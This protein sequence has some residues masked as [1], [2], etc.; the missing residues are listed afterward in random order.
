MAFTSFSSDFITGSSVQA[1][2]LAEALVHDGRRMPSDEQ[3]AQFG[4]AILNETLDLLA[5]SP[6]EDFTTTL[7]EG[8]I[9]GCIRWPSGLSGTPTSP[10]PNCSG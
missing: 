10:D 6:L 8:L 4:R 5:D 9:A 3:L 1:A 2:Q 7:C